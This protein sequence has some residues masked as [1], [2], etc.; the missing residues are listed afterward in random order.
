MG[1]KKAKKRLSFVPI[2]EIFGGANGVSRAYRYLNK[3]YDLAAKGVNR[4]EFGKRI[5]ALKDAYGRQ[6]LGEDKNVVI[7]EEGNAWYPMEA[8]AQELGAAEYEYV[9]EAIYDVER[10]L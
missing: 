9:G 5:E 1:S 4:G 8:E 2:G 3:K 10:D 6:K 7:D